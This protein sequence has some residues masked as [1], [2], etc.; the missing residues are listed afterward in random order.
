[1]PKKMLS[2][3]SPTNQP[4]VMSNIVKSSSSIE[5]QQDF[6]E[7]WVIEAENSCVLIVQTPITSNAVSSC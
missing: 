2:I 1:M 5:N 4:E 7:H 6:H 3:K